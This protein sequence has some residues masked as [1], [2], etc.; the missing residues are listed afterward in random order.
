MSKT[1]TLSASKRELLGKKVGSLRRNGIVPANLFG[2]GKSSIA[3]S[4]EA[5]AAHKVFAEAGK[6][7]PV[8]IS[9]DKDVKELVLI[10]DVDYDPVKGFIRHIAFQIVKKGE[11][12]TAEIPVHLV[13]DCPAERAGNIVVVVNDVVEVEADPMHLPE[14]FEVDKA[15]LVKEDDALLVADITVPKGVELITDPELQLARVEVPRSQIQEE[16]SESAPS[17]EEATPAS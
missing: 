6:N 2:R 3:I 12:V 16:E 8:E 15:N 13:G 7:H 1:L 11:K 14:S 4:I 5:G 10:K 9:V 17:A